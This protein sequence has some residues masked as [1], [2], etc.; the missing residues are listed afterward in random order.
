M[1]RFAKMAIFRGV[2]QLFFVRKAVTYGRFNCQ[3]THDSFRRFALYVCGPSKL[4]E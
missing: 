3:S 4:A 2:Q 1:I